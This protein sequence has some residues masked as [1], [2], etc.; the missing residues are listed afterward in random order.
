MKVSNLI[1]IL[2]KLARKPGAARSLFQQYPIAELVE[3][4]EKGRQSVFP[5]SE[6]DEF[7]K[8]LLGAPIYTRH[9]TR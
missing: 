9:I 4:A 7:G 8:A 6:L 5:L 3:K 2:T 1:N